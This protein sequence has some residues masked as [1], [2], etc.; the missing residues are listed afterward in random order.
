MQKKSRHAKVD[1]DHCKVLE[2]AKYNGKRPKS[3][4]DECYIN[5]N[6]LCRVREPGG[7]VDQE[8]KSEDV[9]SKREC[10]SDEDGV[11]MDGMAQQAVQAVT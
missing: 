8:V 10:K 4:E 6:T 9:S 7:H 2:D 11:E 5:M 1:Q 3:E